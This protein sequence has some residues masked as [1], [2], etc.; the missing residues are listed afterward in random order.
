[1][2]A[3]RA[4]DRRQED[5]D[6]YEPSFSSA[7]P[8][9]APQPAPLARARP[10]EED[11]TGALPAGAALPGTAVMIGTHFHSLDEK[12]R[13]IIPAKM[14]AALTEQFWMMRDEDDNI[15]LYPYATGLDILEHCESM[16]RD[17]PT[18]ENIAAAV[19]RI[20]EAADV[21]TVESSFRV[22][23]PDVL[24]FHAGMI[25]EVVTVGALNHAVLWAR[26]KW[27]EEH[28]SKPA[29]PAVR[30]AQA[31]MMRA[32]ASGAKRDEPARRSEEPAH[33]QAPERAD[34]RALERDTEHL[35]GSG[36]SGGRAERIGGRKAAPAGDG[37]RGA[38]VLKM[39]DLGR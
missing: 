17:Y 18:D 39:S 10:G 9:A 3:E 24:L 5:E 26:E 11:E 25:K 28:G 7:S 20:T 12:G 6:G 37:G 27:E 35:G 8:V 22:P 13:V 4:R 15:G 14:R 36:G 29:T 19:M 21:V 2:P 33:E 38:G 30:K 34:E 31:S 16:L 1:M 23:I 32:A